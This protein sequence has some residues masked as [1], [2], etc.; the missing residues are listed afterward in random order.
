MCIVE[1]KKDGE[2]PLQLG[3]LWQDKQKKRNRKLV[4]FRAK[5]HIRD[6]QTIFMSFVNRLF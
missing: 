2:V 3:M 4:N 5:E 1:V 6:G